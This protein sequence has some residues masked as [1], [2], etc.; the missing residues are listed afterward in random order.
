M[1]KR[2]SRKHIL[3]VLKQHRIA[4]TEQ[5]IQIAGVLLERPQH[6]TAED[7]RVRLRQRR[8]RVSKATVYNTVKL[9]GRTGLVREVVV[10]ASRRFYDSATHPHHHFYNIDTGELQDI[11]DDQV[12]IEKLPEMPDG[13]E[14]ESVEVLIRVRNKPR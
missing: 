14:A 13:A 3:S 8:Q 5:R 7:I 1:H 11:P 4:P 2:L 10:D 12:R 6:L 9:F